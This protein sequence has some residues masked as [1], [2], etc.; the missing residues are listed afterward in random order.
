[1]G[2]N[3]KIEW[4]DDT[5]SP[6]W[7]CV[8]VS[9]A[10]RNCY[11]ENH[12]NR[13]SPGTWGPS[14][15][16]RFFGERHWD[17]P[18]RWDRKAKREGVRRRVFCASMCD[19]FEELP[20]GHP[21]R[22]AMADA[23]SELWA[24]IGD[25]P[26]LDWLLLTKRPENI[27]SV[28]LSIS[29]SN[30]IYPNMWL[31]TTVEDQTTADTRIPA[32]LRSVPAAVHFVSCEPLLEAVDLSRYLTW[33]ALCECN[34]NAPPDERCTPDAAEH[35]IRCNLGTHRVNWVIAGGESGHDARPSHPDWFR[36]LRNQCAKHTNQLVGSTPFLFKQWGAYAPRSHHKD[37]ATG[38]KWGTVGP[39]GTWWPQTTPF[40]GHDDDGLGLAEA[41]MLRL[42]KKDAG[43][44]LDGREHTEFPKAKSI[45]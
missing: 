3:T 33:G 23:R 24:L 15:R 39:D 34:H 6:W 2:S 21:D 44:R 37:V 41:V 38:D 28:M 20:E 9:E 14:G 12:A 36:S 45:A 30:A 31:G 10:C 18:R 29:G 32:L 19:V 4:A 16:R 27:R 35:W 11:A 1:M 43:R 22:I 40:N 17:G 42:G 8:K 25:T 13:F 26:N 7:G 5:F